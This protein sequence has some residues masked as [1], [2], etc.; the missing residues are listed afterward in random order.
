MFHCATHD[1][2]FPYLTQFNIGLTILKFDYTT[3]IVGRY[4][5]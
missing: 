1:T 5:T 4:T 2:I 3:E